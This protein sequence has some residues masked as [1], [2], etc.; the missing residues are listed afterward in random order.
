MVDNRLSYIMDMTVQTSLNQTIK[1][2]WNR[3]KLRSS[4][5]IKKYVI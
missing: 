4:I 3:S 1:E 5:K 2:E